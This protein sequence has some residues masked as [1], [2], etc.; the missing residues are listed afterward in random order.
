MNLYQ[1]SLYDH[2]TTHMMQTRK[3]MWNV[4]KKENRFIGK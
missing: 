2:C 4:T 3:E 1:N